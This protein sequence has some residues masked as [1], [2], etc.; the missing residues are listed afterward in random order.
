MNDSILT[1]QGQQHLD[2]VQRWLQ[3]APDPPE[4]G[5]NIY[6]VFISYRSTDRPWAMAL[7]DAL[8]QAGWEPFLDQYELVPGS[9]LEMSLTEALEASSSGVILWSSN[10]ESSE[11]CKKERNAMD[12]LKQRSGSFNYVFAKLDTEP[13]PLFAQSDLFFEFE[14]S[15]EG[16]RGE[17]LLRLMC[18]M[19]GVS[20]S[21]EAV[22][23]AQKVDQDEQLTLIAVNG[24]IEAENPAQLLD[25]GTSDDPGVLASPNPVL[26]AAQGL[27]SMGENDSAQSVLKHA[28]AYFPKSLRAKQLKGLVLRRLERY[29]DAINV[30]SE[31]KAAGHQD[32][33][34]LGILA[35]A[36]DG[37]YLESGKKLYLRKAREL[38]RMA[39][40]ADP[41]DYYTGINAASKSLF[42]GE[43]AE[44]ERLAAAVYELVKGAADGKDFYGGCTLAEVFLLQRKFDAAKALFEKVIDNHFA[45]AGDLEGTRQQATRICDAHGL[46][47]EDTAEILAPFLLLRD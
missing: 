19:R 4:R 8:K 6:D 5:E 15:P 27:I 26:A 2:H 7:Y 12:V 34:T 46:S 1:E 29:Q 42:L 20:L 40:Q 23:L 30:L 22:K 47:E 33:E 35:A 16:P 21:S 45:R 39:F 3:Y 17:K 13:L 44:S 28:L 31:L 9:N 36:W 11:W 10:T 25:I 24:A 32:P 43:P 37:R 18:G 14:D 41:E 38:Y